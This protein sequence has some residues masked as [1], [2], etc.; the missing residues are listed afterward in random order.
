[1]PKKH[2]P[3]LEYIETLVRDNIPLIAKEKNTSLSYHIASYDEYQVLLHE[4]MVELLVQFFET[5]KPESFADVLEV[6]WSIAQVY[7]FDMNDIENIRLKQ[8]EEMG[9]YEAGVVVQV[10]AS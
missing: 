5:Q 2:T 1:M 10:S 9:G 7:N 6:F 8:R 4:K 3:S